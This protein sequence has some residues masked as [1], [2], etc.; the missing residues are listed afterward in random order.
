MYIRPNIK[1]SYKKNNIG[2]S[3]HDIIM[4]LAPHNVVE[5]G[6]L[7]GYSTVII[8]HALKD[9]GGGKLI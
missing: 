4:E 6:V 2:D 5:F 8:A 7:Y 9:L 1:S 3:I